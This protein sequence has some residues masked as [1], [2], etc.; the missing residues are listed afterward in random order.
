VQSRVSIKEHIRWLDIPMNQ[1]CGDLL[2]SVVVSIDDCRT[3]VFRH[4][5]DLFIIKLRGRELPFF[6]KLPEVHRRTPRPLD[7][8][9]DEIAEVILDA[10]IDARDDV[11]MM[12]LRHYA[13]FLKEMFPELEGIR[14]HWENRLDGMYRQ[15][16]CMA[17]LVDLT[18]AS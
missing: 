4:H 14:K 10:G 18:H 2:S 16:M 6:E 15:E 3:Y 13:R 12:E 5:P 17:R 11:W 7:I 1:T 9:K 8:L